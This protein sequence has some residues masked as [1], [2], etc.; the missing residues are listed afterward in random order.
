MALLLTGY[1]L[2]N[3]AICEYRGVLEGS[4]GGRRR[5]PPLTARSIISAHVGKCGDMFCLERRRYRGHVL[6]IEYAVSPDL[7]IT[8]K[9]GI[10]LAVMKASL[11]SS[12]RKDHYFTRLLLE[13]YAIMREEGVESLIL[14]VL[15]AGDATSLLRG[16]AFVRDNWDLAPHKGDGFIISTRLYDEQ[17]ALS[18]IGRA[19]RVLLG[20]A[21]PMPR[22]GAA[23]RY[24]PYRQSCPYAP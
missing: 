3:M 14:A 1:L 24:C 7:V 17:E 2:Q 19:A 13:A 22:P 5:P 15:Q 4:Q 23:C 6:G 11:T 12:T 8:S 20:E 10:P 21:K 9:D 16:I 18:V